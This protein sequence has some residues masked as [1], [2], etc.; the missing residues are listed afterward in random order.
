PGET[1]ITAKTSNGITAAC[2]I[3]VRVVEADSITLNIDD[4]EMEE[5]DFVQLYATVS[6]KN[7]T[8][9]SVTW[10]SADETVAT[11]DET[12][13]VTA[14]KPGETEITAKT[15]NGITTSC[16]IYVRVVEADS[17]T[18]NIDNTEITE[19]DYVLLYATIFPKNTTDKSVTWASADE[20]VATVDETGMVTAISP[21]KTSI[22]ATTANGITVS[23]IVTVLKRII[24]AESISL[25]LTE[26]ELTEGDSVH[27]TATVSPDNTDDM[28]VTWSSYDTAV[29]T[30]DENGLITAIAPGETTVTASTANGVTASCIV[31][32][33][34]RI[35]HAESILINLS[36][37]E[38]TEGE[39]IHL[40][41]IVLPD[42]TDDQTVTWTSYNTA[43]ATIDENGL[44]TA[45]APGKA[46]V[47]AST[48]NGVTASCIV[49]VLKRI[50]HAESITINLPEAE[51]SEGESVRL[52][53]TVSPDGTVERTVTWT[54]GDGI[55]ATVDETGRVT[56]IKPGETE[57]TA[58]TA[59]GV[60]ASCRISVKSSTTGIRE[61]DR[62]K[63]L[64][65]IIKDGN[66]IINENIPVEIFNLSGVRVYKSPEK[67][68][69]GLPRGIYILRANGKTYKIRI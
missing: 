16:R 14:I 42:E 43:V 54:S 47:T 36:E 28:T 37:A 65:F 45:I 13:M 8:D 25:N 10:A 11:V 24:Y 50:I 59:N 69:G 6:P 4:A 60:S 19:G 48:A 46:T 2:R 33:L 1:E 12:G 63:D 29:A 26:A 30:I 57:I 34:K 62:E 9:K 41:A 39:S 17:V 23:C 21:G 38:L 53:A 64:P 22:T 49:T 3:Y 5:G 18:I 35:I 67:L 32:V 44:I 40:T 20:T 68:I 56:A 27:L 66:L 7:T 15:A 58:T 31:T 51:L 52:T 61:N 55:I